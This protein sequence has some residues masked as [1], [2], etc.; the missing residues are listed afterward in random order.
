MLDKDKLTFTERLAQR[1]SSAKSFS[2]DD[3]RFALPFGA[4]VFL[5][6][7]K[8]ERYREASQTDGLVRRRWKPEKDIDGSRLGV[9]RRV[10]RVVSCLKLSESEGQEEEAGWT[11]ARHSHSSRKV[12]LAVLVGLDVRRAEPAFDEVALAFFQSSKR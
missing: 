11:R 2:T 3:F 7:R 9:A 4:Y 1:S 5:R 10:L 6:T 8:K 12:V